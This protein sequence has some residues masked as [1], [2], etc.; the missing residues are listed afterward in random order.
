MKK[1][2]KCKIEK[3]YSFFGVRKASKDGYSY[4]CKE[5]KVLIDKEYQLNNPEKIKDRNK[6]YYIENKDTIKETSS[7]YYIENKE[8]CNQKNINSYYLNRDERIEKV[9]EYRI[10]NPDKIKSKSKKYYIENKDNI[11]IKVKLWAEKN[12][13][14]IK[15]YNTKYREINKDEI[16]VYKVYYYYNNRNK[17]NKYQREYYKTR[18]YIKS[19]RSILYRYFKYFS[20]EK[21]N[22]TKNILGYSFLL[23]K[24]RIECQFKEG[25]SWDNYGEWEID[26]KKPLSKFNK[27]T[28]PSIVNALSNLQPLWKEENRTKSNKWK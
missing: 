16:K 5:C 9:K 13:D 11:K 6:K 19:W 10:K 12:P 27:E 28:K 26:H 25:M 7:K 8:A 22:S 23:L 21:K 14:K 17:I 18:K 4:I 1:C 15:E 20:V 2:S 3:D 24:E